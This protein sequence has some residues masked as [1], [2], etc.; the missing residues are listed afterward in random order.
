MPRLH[1]P[2]FKA[3]SPECPLCRTRPASP[4][5]VIRRGATVYPSQIP[6]RSVRPWPHSATYLS[7]PSLI[8]PCYASR[9]ARP[10]PSHPLE[11]HAL[12]SL[13]LYLFPHYFFRRERSPRQ[14]THSHPVH[15][16]DR[17]AVFIFFICFLAAYV[18][19]LV[20]RLHDF[21]CCCS[22]LFCRISCSFSPARYLFYSFP[23]LH[24]LIPCSST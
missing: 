1:F 15:P 11:S 13:Q 12:C 4:F 6:R 24:S 20:L 7:M 8:V 3:R 9:H 10:L 21:L 2:F 5:R 19:F 17:M 18:S 22:V 23:S 16:L 14:S